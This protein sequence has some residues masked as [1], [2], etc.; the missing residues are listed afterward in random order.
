MTFVKNSAAIGPLRPSTRAGADDAGAVDE[1]IDATHVL[2]R[3]FHRRDHFGLGGDV[4]FDEDRALAE[5]GR[6]G[7]T[8]AFLNIE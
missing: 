1:E 7:A 2:A 5:L 6:G 8:R 4:A 3:R